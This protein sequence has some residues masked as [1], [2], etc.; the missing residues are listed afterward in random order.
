MADP[1]RLRT[2]KEQTARLEERLART[3]QTLDDICKK[4]KTPRKDPGSD[5]QVAKLEKDLEDQRLE[6]EALIGRLHEELEAVQFERDNL[7]RRLEA[8]AEFDDEPTD[9]HSPDDLPSKKS[10]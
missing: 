8:A 10:D 2:M 6:F 7:V 5:G 1:D 3:E 9:T 4:L